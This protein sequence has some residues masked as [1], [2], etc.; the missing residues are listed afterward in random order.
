VIE[1]MAV[2][3]IIPSPHINPALS[4]FICS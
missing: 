4:L 3:L 2:A 1:L